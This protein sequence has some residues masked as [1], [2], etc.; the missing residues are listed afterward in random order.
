MPEITLKNPEGKTISLSKLRGKV[1]LVDFWASWCGP[2]RAENPNITKCY[3]KY[4][5]KK[6]QRGNGFDVFS[7]SLDIKKE[8]WTN[9]I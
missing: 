3:A 1:V 7:I 4:K 5:D 6:S 8:R 2:C 9:A